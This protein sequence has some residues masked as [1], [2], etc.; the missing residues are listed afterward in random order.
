MT[1]NTVL[2]NKEGT[3]LAPAT[4][5]EQVAYDNTMNVKQAIDSR[6]SDEEYEVLNQR[7]N[8]FASLPDGSTTGDA[9]LQDIRVGADGTVYESAGEAVRGQI[10]GL[11]SALID[12]TSLDEYT[13]ND[14]IYAGSTYH[15][16]LNNTGSK[17]YH[18][19]NKNW[20]FIGSKNKYKISA[21]CAYIN[22]AWTV[23]DPATIT[24]AASLTI[25]ESGGTYDG[26]TNL[27]N[28]DTLSPEQ[29]EITIDKPEG[30]NYL[31]VD[32][33]YTEP[34][35][36]ELNYVTGDFHVQ[37]DGVW[38]ESIKNE[39]VTEEKLNKGA[40]TEEKIAE[41]AV[42]KEKLKTGTV[43]AK[44]LDISFKRVYLEPYIAEKGLETYAQTT[45]AY[46]GDIPSNI[47]C[48]ELKAGKK[49]MV[50]GN[51]IPRN[52][53]IVAD[54]TQG[55][56]YVNDTVCFSSKKIEWK[57]GMPFT[58]ADLGV[59]MIYS[60]LRKLYSN[61]KIT[62]NETLKNS[63]T[64][65]RPSMFSPTIDM[66]VYFGSY[67]PVGSQYLIPVYTGSFFCEVDEIPYFENETDYVS[68]TNDQ[69]CIANAYQKNY[70]SFS[71]TGLKNDELVTKIFASE[72][73][74][75]LEE[76]LFRGSRN[77]SDYQVC[78]YVIGDSITYAASNAGLQNAWRKYI[79]TKLNLYEM[80]LAVSG[81]TLTY[82]YAYDFNGNAQGSDSYDL[83]MTGVRGIKT[84]LKSTQNQWSTFS[85]G[86]LEFAIVALGT[87]DFG[88]NAKLG[89][90]ETLDDDGTFYG[91]TYQLFHFLHDDMEIP[92]VIFVAPFKRQN[93]N[94]KNEAEVPYTIYE[95]V[96]ALAEISLL[97]N[98]M[99]VLDCTDRWYLNYDDPDIRAKSFIDYVHI[100]GYAHHM[101]TIDLAIFIQNIVAV[102]G[103]RHYQ[104]QFIK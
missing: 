33:G 70:S 6:I 56:Q 28:T 81:T 98:D 90:V 50:I 36:V 79:S 25:I 34:Q 13:D 91:A 69:F 55:K 64:T 12:I 80:A 93:W 30:A 3:P 77:I 23:E 39:A 7:M 65:Y 97:E 57:S 48:I 85:K 62:G 38:T 66:Y 89:S 99:Y 63:T 1:L 75:M 104:P 29:H 102:R 103:L 78:A 5:A 59:G 96:H 20:N 53:N 22:Y 84:K 86:M 40:V 83:E 44:R 21:I 74:K 26:Y 54:S 100:T 73:N 32:F 45:R 94:V 52:E 46:T 14:G 4:T 16:A 71:T 31:L 88:N 15:W 27:G 76:A 11:K 35:Y 67:E 92:Y 95:L 24:D 19:W 72:K 42:G 17:H 60:I 2:T 47:Y 43:D 8:T 49:Y 61:E 68:T 58:I 82:G 41:E 87:N 101:F 51:T 9:E 37:K 10:S 18:L